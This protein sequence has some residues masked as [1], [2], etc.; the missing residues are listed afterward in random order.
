MLGLRLASRRAYGC[1]LLLVALT[2]ASCGEPD[3]GHIERAS[4]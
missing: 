2:S 3:C 1:M 4:G